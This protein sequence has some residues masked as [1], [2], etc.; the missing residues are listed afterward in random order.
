MKWNKIITLIILLSLF[1]YVSETEK[2]IS[3]SFTS[4]SLQLHFMDSLQTTGKKVLHA[5]IDKA[6][7]DAEKRMKAISLLD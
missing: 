1:A 7:P 3:R 5:S 4:G 2:R 6:L